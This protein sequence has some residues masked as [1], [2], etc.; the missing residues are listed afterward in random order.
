MPKDNRMELNTTQQLAVDYDGRHLLI[1]AGPGTGKTHTLTQR[2]IKSLVKL[3]KDQKALALTFTKK[4]AEE[5]Q[6]CIS[7]N[8][9]AALVEVN[10]F[11]GFALNFLKRHSKQL[12][13]FNMLDLE[14]GLEVFKALWPD[15]SIVK[16]R[17]RIE[18]I[19]CKKTLEILDEDVKEYNRFLRSKNLLDYDDLLYEAKSLL[20]E[21]YILLQTQKS[22]P[23]VF[24]DE[25]QDI[26]ALQHDILRKIVGE[27]GRVTA[28]GDPNQAI[29]G[30]RGS[31]VKFFETFSKDFV[32]THVIHLST[33]YR[34][35]ANIVE[36]SSQMIAPSRFD[37]PELTAN[38]FDRGQLI[39]YEA[40][41]D[42]SEAEYVIKQIE[43][44]VGGTSMF[45]HDSKRVGMTSKAERSFEDFAILYR[46]NS[47]RKPL[48]EALKRSGIPY[49]VSGE[50]SL[51]SDDFMNLAAE[52][53]SLLT[54]HAA[55]GLEFPVVFIIGCE[56]TL[57]PLDLEGFL[58]NSDEERRLFYV[59]MTRAKEELYLTR[60]KKRLCFGKWTENSW[61]P[62]IYDIEED[63][64]KRQEVNFKKRLKE[65]A[66]QLS[67]FQN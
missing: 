10:T 31:D 23:F 34:S 63:L 66:T 19:C 44:M 37:V 38:I 11:H 35:S 43:A 14:N 57:M 17:K 32:Q 13:S 39:T 65:K 42:K 55:K 20:E 40:P 27:T 64:K 6:R 1:V 3:N 21:E 4:T 51:E 52:K 24:V 47:L 67:L 22:Y 16:I 15:L 33:N 61:S 45:S 2:V 7:L 18:K 56:E 29:Y 28:I 48:E 46:L 58:C 49:S 59:A 26:N 30:F 41:T 50:K 9:D 5:M 12:S 8:G 36:A 60:S 53:V 25:Y 54:M 62:F